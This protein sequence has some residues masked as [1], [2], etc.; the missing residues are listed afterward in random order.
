MDVASSSQA[1]KRQGSH[2]VATIPDQ[3][4]LTKTNSI[5]IH[6]FLRE[7]DQ[8]A[9]E[10]NKIALQISGEDVLSTDISRPVQLKF[11]VNSEWLESVIHLR[12][13]KGVT[14]YGDHTDN[15]LQMY[16]ISKTESTK[17]VV[18]IDMLDKFVEDKS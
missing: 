14:K 11:C 7:Y 2:V 8:Y 6:A 12:F 15:Q 13:I 10:V 3:P 9:R 16:P 5:A 1:S 18:T 17:D 4:R